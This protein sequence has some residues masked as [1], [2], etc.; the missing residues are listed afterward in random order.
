LFGRAV[1]YSLVFVALL[2]SIA[3]ASQAADGARSAAKAKPDLKVALVSSPPESLAP[4]GTF[5]LSDRTRN[6]GR[7][8]SKPSVTRYYLSLD[9]R[10]SSGDV[11]LGQRSV[12]RLRRGKASSGEVEL[13]L[14]QATPPGSYS[15]LACADALRRNR[16][17]NERNNC[18]P[19]TGRLEVTSPPNLAGG[20]AEGGQG[21]AGGGSGAGSGN[22]GGGGGN[23]GG[24]GD[25]PGDGGD[26]PGGGGDNP[27]DGVGAPTACADGIDNDTD[28]LT[29]YR[30]SGGDPGCEGLTDSSERQAGAACDDG[31][32]ND[33]D[34]LVDYSVLP[35]G[36]PGCDSPTDPSEL[37]GTAGCADGVDNDVDGL[38]DYRETG[39]DPDC[40]S[41]QDES[42]TAA[43]VCVDGADGDG[44]RDQ[45]PSVPNAWLDCILSTGQVIFGGC[46]PNY[47]D[48]NGI[49]QDGCEYGPVV[50]TSPDEQCDGVDNNANGMIDEGIP[51]PS[52]A[53]G[54]VVCH[55][56]SIVVV[57]NP[58]YT[59]ANSNPFDG[60]EAAVVT[61]ARPVAP[62]W[63][64]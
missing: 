26:N 33:P 36:D 3:G 15:V 48:I 47:W 22:P 9:E 52:D 64:A 58:G 57:C 14:P 20:P 43:F 30:E 21:S 42:E 62:A 2:V 25:N 10:F 31:L 8:A 41:R 51:L 4:G 59:D 40:D 46:D 49:L 11:L 60:C 17:K 23:P 28:G 29:D 38:T 50:R 55:L 1:K 5:S 32:S 53:N 16:E 18:R 39:G 54:H 63:T 24:G 27:G 37:G 6:G 13:T 35:G 34:G 44:Q 61:G 7:K 12:P 19:A 45:R 56:G